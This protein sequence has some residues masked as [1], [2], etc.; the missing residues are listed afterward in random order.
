MFSV[1][2][3]TLMNL[4][5]RSSSAIA[6]LASSTAGGR[7]LSHSTPIRLGGARA[8][9][10]LG[11]EGGAARGCSDSPVA[12]QDR[13]C[14]GRL[15]QLVWV[16][17]LVAVEAVAADDDAVHDAPGCVHGLDRQAVGDESHRLPA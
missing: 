7:D 13:Q 15:G 16:P 2:P 1:A 6:W 9:D 14:R 4:N 17:R 5:G 12:G 8:V 3:T 11:R 10:G